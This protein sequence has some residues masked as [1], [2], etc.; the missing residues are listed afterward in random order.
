MQG[1]IMIPDQTQDI[2][3]EEYFSI[4]R[5]AGGESEGLYAGCAALASDLPLEKIRCLDVG[6]GRGELLA[7]LWKQGLK[8]GHGIDFS[9]VAVRFS[10]ARMRPL[11][12]DETE[13]R[14]R[15][16]S[17]TQKEIYPSAHF[18]LIWMTDVVEHLPP[19]VLLEGLTNVAKWL[20]PDGR[21]VIHTFPTLGPHR[22]FS[23]LM[24]LRGQ[25]DKL[26]K[27][28]RIHCNVQSRKSL[29]EVLRQAGLQV[30]QMWL[31][32]DLLLTSSV[33]QQMAP[34][35]R[36]RLIGYLF[37]HLLRSR[38]VINLL[39]WIGLA[40]YAAPSIYCLCT[41]AVMPEV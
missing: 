21:L 6:C 26:E 15:Q 14:I 9:P 40:E 13:Q 3:S 10:R 33:F 31:Q 38:M 30:D 25:R 41:P 34:G 12:G 39:S 7:F 19:P 23:L 27:I 24:T 22:L 18:D 35:W 37:G 11:L 29:R 32:N 4:M 28:N 20:K 16:A 5:G 36:K 2:Y 8:D 17:I 1:V